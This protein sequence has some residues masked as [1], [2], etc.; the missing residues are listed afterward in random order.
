MKWSSPVISIISLI[1]AIVEGVPL[2]EKLMRGQSNV[3]RVQ[4]SAVFLLAGDSTTA[5]QSS[6]GGGWG[7]GFKNYTLEEPSFAINY[8]HNGATTGSFIDGGD[9]ATVLG[10]VEEYSPTMEAYVTIQFGHNDQKIANYTDTFKTNLRRMISDVRAANGNPI[11]VTP[12][13]RRNFY[14]NG[15]I[16][17]TLGA[18]AGYAIEVADETGA[19]YINLL[20]AS[21]EYLEKIGEVAARRLDLVDGDQTHVNVNGSIVFGRMVSDLIVERLPEVDQW[22]EPDEKLSQDIKNGVASY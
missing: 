21:V 8:G 13:S 7:D 18:W 16:I 12:L 2:K 15:T 3:R 6:N 20:S 10:R 5:T 4:E 19:P 22:V 11:I 1:A 9:W 17:D 14:S